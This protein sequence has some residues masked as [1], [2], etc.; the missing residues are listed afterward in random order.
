MVVG[1]VL[2]EIFSDQRLLAR[3][4]YALELRLNAAR[5]GLS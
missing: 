2:G 5:E 1:E 3:H 4:R